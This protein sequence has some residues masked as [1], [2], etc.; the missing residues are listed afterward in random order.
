MATKAH[1]EV[2]ERLLAERASVDALLLSLLE[3]PTGADWT[4]RIPS[5]GDI[6]DMAAERLARDDAATQTAALQQRLLMIDDALARVDAGTYGRCSVCDG[7]IG[8]ER[9]AAL[10]F[11]TV[12][13]RDQARREHLRRA[14]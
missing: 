5:T 8:D 7:P 12:C 14:G 3:R 10:P 11:V 1:D 2:R 9:L 6:A 13:V 4:G